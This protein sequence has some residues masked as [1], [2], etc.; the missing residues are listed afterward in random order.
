M[1]IL[2]FLPAIFRLTVMN[3]SI[4]SLWPSFILI[5]IYFMADECL[6]TQTGIWVAVLLGG[7]EFIYTRIKEK[8]YDKIILA[9][10]LFFC[11][12]GLISIW[13]EGSIIARL[14]PAIVE[15]A[16]CIL[17]GILSFSHMNLNGTLPASYR[18]NLHFSEEQMN[19]M[20]KMLRFLFYLIAIHTL[21][22][23]TAL[24][25]LPEK[26]AS[27]ISSPLL[28]ILLGIYFLTLFIRNRFLRTRLKKEE[29][30]PVVNEEGAVIGRAPRSLCH[31][32]SRLLHPVIHLHIIN[33]QN[34][35]FLQ[36]RSLKK[37]FLPGMWDTA[38]GGHI[39]WNE[40]IE[41]ALKRETYEELGITDFQVQF[42]DKYIWESPR[43]RELVFTFLCTHYNQIHIDNDEVEE[44]RFWTPS[45]L[46]EGIKEQLLTP[47]L[48][49]EYHLL[50]KKRLKK[51][52]QRT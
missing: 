40:K 32:G 10:T 46:E 6:G 41:D 34:A 23:Y 33:A 50:L 9:T 22:S 14:Q 30:L 45:E 15:T 7:I 29:W 20:R 28:Y 16:L 43:E 17:L 42:L 47:N 37:D 5:F 35:L 3:H 2:L 52:E 18:K 51:Y 36:K 27:F 1:K 26:T 11:I 31:S 38:V 44:G 4:K 49:H 21:F 8:T 13:M 12:P 25:L 24:L 19:Q 39:S 48:I